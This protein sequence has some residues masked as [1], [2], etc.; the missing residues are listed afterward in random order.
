MKE[1]PEMGVFV[2]RRMQMY[3][4]QD[5]DKLRA[6][7]EKMGSAA[8]ISKFKTA[9]TKAGNLVLG[10]IQSRAKGKLKNAYVLKESKAKSSFIIASQIQIAKGYAYAVPCELGHGLVYY[11]HKT[12]TYIDERP[13]MRPAA[14]ESVSEV[15]EIIGAELDEVLKEFG[16]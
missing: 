7:I 1:R 2:L 6:A 10:K 9:T 3:E 8:V 16:G 13:T 12:N 4:L 5:S 11:G 14:D 15:E